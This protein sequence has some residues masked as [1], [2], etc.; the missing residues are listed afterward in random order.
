MQHILYQ[1]QLCGNLMTFFYVENSTIVAVEFRTLRTN[2]IF[3]LT[4]LPCAWPAHRL[5]SATVTRTV[6]VRCAD[7]TIDM[8]VLT[9][10]MPD[11]WLISV[12]ATRTTGP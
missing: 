9:K 2:K 10:L 8:R 5:T 6:H 7:I 3:A 1:Q 12:P 11:A 4:T